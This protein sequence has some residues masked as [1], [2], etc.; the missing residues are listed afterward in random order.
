MKKLL[1]LLVAAGMAAAMSGCESVP[2]TDK[3][4]EAATSVKQDAGKTADS[5]KKDAAKT[6]DS[7]KKDATKAVDSAKKDATKA[8]DDLKK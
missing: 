5:V 4:K 1:T 3:L 8:L 2:G 6:A 7:A